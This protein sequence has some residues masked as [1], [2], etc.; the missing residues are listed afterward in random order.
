[1]CPP[2]NYVTP[3]LHT[4][5]ATATHATLVLWLSTISTEVRWFGHLSRRFISSLLSLFPCMSSPSLST[6]S[7]M[8]SLSLHSFSILA[9]TMSSSVPFLGMNN[10]RHHELNMLPMGSP[11]KVSSWYEFFVLL[12]TCLGA[13]NF[14]S[15]FLS[16]LNV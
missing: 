4:P 5:T 14:G 8:F 3:S 10:H 9:C 15:N 7:S 11:S 16:V 2:S 12:T 1:M 6:L 13:E